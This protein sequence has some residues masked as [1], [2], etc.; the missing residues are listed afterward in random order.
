M[1]INASCASVD[2]LRDL[3]QVLRENDKVVAM[4]YVTWCPFC[5]RALPVFEKLAREEQRYLLLVADDEER[6]ADLYGIDVFPTLILFEKGKIVK[7]LDAKPGIGI[8]DKQIAD[9]IQ[10]SPPL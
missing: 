10:S 5:R 9:F 4:V 7:R 8:A 1:G 2:N 6:V 3:E